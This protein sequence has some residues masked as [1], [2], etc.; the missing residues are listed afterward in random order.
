MTVND[1]F[2]T[3]SLA[4]RGRCHTR[5]RELL[6]DRASILHAHERE[7]LLD[8]ADALLF[9]EPAGPAKRVAGHRLLAAMVESDRWLPEPAA[10]A[11]AALDGC[12]AGELA[13]R[14]GS[15]LSMAQRVSSLRRRRP[16]FSRIRVRWFCTVRGEM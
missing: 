10:E 14:E 6:A 2:S 8:A 12:G 13:A 16:V 5:L 1:A 4:E 3:G 7:L 9:D 15:A 11:R